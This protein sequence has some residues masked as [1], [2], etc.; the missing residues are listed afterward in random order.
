[1]KDHKDDVKENGE[2]MKKALDPDVRTFA[3]NEYQTVSAHKKDIDAI[4]ARMG[5]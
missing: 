5:K 2:T 3:S 1:M 4:H